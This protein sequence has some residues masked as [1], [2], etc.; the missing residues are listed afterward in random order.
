MGL[1]LDEALGSLRLTTGYSTTEEEMM[2]ALEVIASVL[3]RAGAS[4]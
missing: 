2:R 4:A 1:D 3:T